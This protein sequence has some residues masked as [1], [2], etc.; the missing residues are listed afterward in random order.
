MI[1][2]LAGQA[3]S[4]MDA[5]ILAVAAPSLR[6]DLHPS[7]AELQMV[8][9]AYTLVFG[10]L[11]ITG[12]RL[13]DILGRRRAFLLGLSAFTLASLAAGRLRPCRR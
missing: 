4:V 6:A 3:M 12:A 7:G 2:L 10:V 9:V 8:V 13:G 11:V 5:S 1:I